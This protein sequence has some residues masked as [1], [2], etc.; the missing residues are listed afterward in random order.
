MCMLDKIL[1]NKYHVLSLLHHGI[2]GDVWLAEHIGFSAK[3]V[4]KVIEKS[5][6]QYTVLIGEAKMLQQCRHP[7]IPIIYDI[8]EFDTQTYIVEEFIQG[9]NLKQYILRERSISASLL[10]KFSVQLCE[11]LQFLHNPIRAILYLDLKPENI[12]LSNDQLK[13]V[14]FGSAISLK[15]EET[16]R[17]IFGTPGYCAPEMKENGMLTERTDI[18]CL[19]RCMEYMLLH[20]SRVPKGYRNIVEK[21]LRKDGEEYTTAEQILRDLKGIRRRR[22]REKE[23]EIL[24]AVTGVFSEYDG[25][26]AALQLAAY[27]RR[28][29]K[30]PVLYLDCSNSSHMERL[31]Q[32]KGKEKNRGEQTDFV[33]ERDGIT[34]IKRVAPQEIMGWCGRG[35]KYV[36]CCFGK[37]SPLLSNCRFQHC[38][39][40]GAVTAFS[41]EEWKNFVTPLNTVQK[42]SVVLTGGDEELAK[43]EFGT[44]CRVQ[45]LFPYFR[46]FETNF[47]LNRQM[48]R[49]LKG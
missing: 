11:I 42:V 15:E 19:G 34:V 47:P 3:R 14:D 12:L 23:K 1:L 43:A 27:L 49:L 31:E 30:T 18:Y 9:E 22:A 7:S 21:C 29:Y 45:K 13:L 24:Y 41:L 6:P 4:L 44:M 39:C 40:A 5:H 36:V 33:F 10:L 32:F 37:K 28:R 2:G 20:T 38:F 16:E 8:L 35:Y 46:A 48:K 25:S 17:F 26:A